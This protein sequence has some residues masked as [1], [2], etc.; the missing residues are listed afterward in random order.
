MTWN[1]HVLGAILV[2]VFVV[3]TRPIVVK[4]SF[5]KTST[6]VFYHN[7]STRSST[8]SCL[9][10]LLVLWS[11]FQTQLTKRGL[12]TRWA[13]KI[14]KPCFLRALMFFIRPEMW[15]SIMTNT[16]NPTLT[17][18]KSQKFNEKLIG[19]CLC[20]KLIAGLE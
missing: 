16:S 20:A 6:R 7:Q 14:D 18:W 2:F 4:N 3:K 8:K 11:L 19:I 13:L 17:V 5:K 10:N 1:H 15:L 12:S 9:A